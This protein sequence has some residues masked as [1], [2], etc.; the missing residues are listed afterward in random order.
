[1]ISNTFGKLTFAAAAVALFMV[2]RHYDKLNEA[3][4]ESANDPEITALSQKVQESSD[5][6]PLPSDHTSPSDKQEESS[7][8][9][10]SEASA[11]A[12]ESISSAEDKKDGVQT[13]ADSKVLQVGQGCDDKHYI[14]ALSF[15]KSPNPEDYVLA[16]NNFKLA[17]ES[18]C[19]KATVEYAKMLIAGKGG[20]KDLQTA[21]KILKK[22]A[23]NNVPGA[24]EVLSSIV[25]DSL[26]KHQTEKEQILAQAKSAASHGDIGAAGNA[27][28]MLLF[29]EAGRYPDGTKNLKEAGDY[30]L[31]AA[32]GGDAES[33]K[34]L[35]HMYALGFMGEKDHATAASWFL[36]ASQKGSMQASIALALQYYQG[37][38]VERNVPAAAKLLEPYAEKGDGESLYHLGKIY[39]NGGPGFEKSS[40]EGLKL[41]Q[42]S[43]DAGYMPAI[44]FMASVFEKGM[45]VAKD[46][47]K[48]RN[49][50]KLLAENG[51]EDGTFAY[52]NI[53]FK[54]GNKQEAAKWLKNAADKKH[55]RSMAKLASMYMNG[56]GGLV[57]DE[58]K[59]LSMMLDA[60]KRGDP[61]AL[62]YYAIWTSEGMA[63]L[64]KDPV[65]ALE[66]FEK[67]AEAGNIYS[68][69]R[70]GYSYRKAIG[71]EKNYAKAMY[72][73][74]KAAENGY[75]KA[76]T[77]LGIM[78]YDGQGTER[79]AER[80]KEWLL[81][82]EAAGDAEATKLLKWLSER[83][84]SG[85]N[86]LSESR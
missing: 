72:W 40:S 54:E 48:A 9:Q 28:S 12:N 65:R 59:S 66:L 53:L 4:D 80:S 37:I 61:M 83:Q 41:L 74:Q 17:H 11:N 56:E 26:E 15:A 73:L 55:P 58:Q 77:Q 8:A 1:M 79:S 7:P 38:G 10:K 63:G 46:P 35:G 52:A 29:G 81:K 23:E 22:A 43:A 57:K 21:N 16:R 2:A 51:H 44:Y 19:G 32:E 64:Q 30:C 39:L 6:K 75:A 62:A 82:A 50:Y 45:G 42:K 67:A 25:K 47:A 20:A 3:G 14:R 24:A 60:A 5:K 78:H 70:T 68:M 84:A 85:E 33:M 18:G 13:V 34:N 49:Y 76:M 86:D 27:C 71:V 31:M 69:F 36:K